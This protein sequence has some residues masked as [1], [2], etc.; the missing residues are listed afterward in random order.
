VLVDTQIRANTSGNGNN[1]IGIWL[2]RGGSS[3][4]NPAYDG[5]GYYTSYSYTNSAW[6]NQNISYL[7]SPSTTSSTTYSLY[8]SSYGGNT[9]ALGGGSSPTYYPTTITLMEIAA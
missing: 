9:V 3:I 2:Y 1:G 7:D 8:I 5:S 4:K 6:I